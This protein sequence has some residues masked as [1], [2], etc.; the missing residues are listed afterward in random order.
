MASKKGIPHIATDSCKG[1]GLCV[2]VCP[3]SV[4]AID[5]GLVNVKGYNPAYVQSPDKCIGCASCALICPDVVLTISRVPKG[6]E[7]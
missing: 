4:L 3:G 2:S 1:C 7:G 6:E 5:T